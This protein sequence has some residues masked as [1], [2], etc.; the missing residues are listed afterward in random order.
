MNFT[1]DSYCDMYFSQIPTFQ[2]CVNWGKLELLR[3]YFNQISWV[4]RI[5]F[6]DSV[7]SG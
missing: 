2:L 1:T 3:V 5:F 7:I 4:T 6:Q